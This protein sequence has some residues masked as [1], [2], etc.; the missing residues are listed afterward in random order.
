MSPTVHNHDRAAA[1]CGSSR[2]SKIAGSLDLIEFGLLQ[3]G[4]EA[5]A[6]I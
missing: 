5:P 3:S 2:E 6:G 4:G 1:M